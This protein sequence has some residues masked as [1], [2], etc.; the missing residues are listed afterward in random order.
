MPLCLFVCLSLVTECHSILSWIVSVSETSASRLPTAE[1][2]PYHHASC[3]EGAGCSCE[4]VWLTLSSAQVIYLRIRG[5]S[6]QL[7]CLV[8]GQ[9]G[10]QGPSCVISRVLGL[11][12]GC[13]SLG[14]RGPGSL[15]KDE[16]YLKPALANAG[17]LK[18]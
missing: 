13:E 16:R 12:R 17:A 8:G 4:S 15:S 14:W 5:Q 2:Q 9:L 10:S 11:G 3:L 6:Q 1:W 7:K 18:P